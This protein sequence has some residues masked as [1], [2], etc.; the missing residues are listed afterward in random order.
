MDTGWVQVFVLTLAECVAPA[1]KSVCQQSQFELSFLSRADCEFAL[2]QLIELKSQSQQ[3]IVDKARSGCAPTTVQSKVFPDE[4]AASTALSDEEG[5]REPQAAEPGEPN[6]PNEPSKSLV[7]HQERLESLK[8]CDDT[9]G[10]APC[11]MG[12]IIIEGAA[13]D[14][15]VWRRE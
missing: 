6:E 10:V 9:A 5:W 15:E 1:G 4:A 14:V 13:Q 11:K 2:E 12:E 3:V 8:A 7:S